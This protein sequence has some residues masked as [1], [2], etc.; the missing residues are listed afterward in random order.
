MKH[1]LKILSSLSSSARVVDGKLILSFPHALTPVVWQMDL[2][3][4]KAS[5]LEVREN[6]TKNNYTLVLKSPRSDDHDIASFETRAQAVEALMAVARAFE[7]AHGQIR[8]LAATG[9]ESYTT[10]AHPHQ[11]PGRGAGKWIAAILGVL[12]F[13]ILLNIWGSFLP[14]YP[15]GVSGRP[16]AP[17]SANAA[18][19]QSGVPL[20]ADDFL[21]AQQP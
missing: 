11:R 19:S 8:P 14:R 13:L 7:S 9:N 18:P 5:A 3:Q 1:A 6:A 2:A 21:N 17:S 20:S 4:A 16:I 10:S 12:L 15:E